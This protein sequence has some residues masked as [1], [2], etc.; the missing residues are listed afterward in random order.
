V[1]V[2]VSNLRQKMSDV[3]FGRRV[4][5]H[6]LHGFYVDGMT[7]APVPAKPARRGSLAPIRHASRPALRRAG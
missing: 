6:K 3:G 1:A 5:T 7:A 2:R 4:K